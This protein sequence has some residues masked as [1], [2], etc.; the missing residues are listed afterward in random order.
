MVVVAI[1]IVYDQCLR[2]I[3]LLIRLGSR[4]LH[5]NSGPT[6]NILSLD[7]TGLV[8]RG[9][10]LSEWPSELVVYLHVESRSL[11]VSLSQ[12]WIKLNVRSLVEIHIDR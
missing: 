8:D 4:W 1:P 9:M 6:R 7:S 2:F 3:M 5:D 11:L 12:N 10:V